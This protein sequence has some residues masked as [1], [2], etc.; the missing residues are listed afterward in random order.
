M[1]AQWGLD[2]LTGSSSKDGGDSKEDEKPHPEIECD[3]SEVPSGQHVSVRLS[4]CQDVQENRFWIG[5]Y[6]YTI[7]GA[8]GSVVVG[9]TSQLPVIRVTEEL[10]AKGSFELPTLELV[11]G[12]QYVVSLKEGE[13][14]PL[15][16]VLSSTNPFKILPDPLANQARLIEV[17][18]LSE[19]GDGK[20]IRRASNPPQVVAI[21]ASPREKKSATLPIEKPLASKVKNASSGGSVRV[22]PRRAIP[23]IDISKTSPRERG[24]RSVIEGGL[25]SIFE[26]PEA[27]I[28]DST[29]VS[30]VSPTGEKR[31]PRK[32][33]SSTASNISPRTS[34]SRISPR[35]SG[36]DVRASSPRSRTTSVPNLPNRS[37][38]AICKLSFNASNVSLNKG[39]VCEILEETNDDGMVRLRRGSMVG[40]V[41]KENLMF[42]TSPRTSTRESISPRTSTRES[43]KG[44]SGDN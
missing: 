18:L 27:P 23:K 4:E 1:W 43:P 39:D 33:R 29:P 34:I 13:V 10:A 20:I 3:I 9:L 38:R 28:V 17:P 37:P 2:K 6:Q 19:L 5:V 24:R 40:L 12:Q 42:S 36:A 31:S 35:T 7:K 44:Q 32:S 22:S 30:I 41:P 26:A 8:Q 25:E 14:W 21:P 15:I 11:V 16:T